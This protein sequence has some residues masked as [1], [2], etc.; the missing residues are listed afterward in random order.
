MNPPDDPLAYADAVFLPPHK[1]IGGPGTPGI[2]ALRRE[3]CRNRVPTVPGGGTV[4]YVNAREH[5]Y[6]DDPEQREEGGTPAIIESI[7]AG[8]VFQLKE[9][10]QA[11]GGASCAGPYGHR[12]L[13]I[14]LERSHQFAREISR[15]CEGIKPAWVR[16]SFNYFID[17]RVFEYVVEAVKLVAEH[18]WK[19]LPDYRFDPV[20]GLW[21]HR[22]GPLDPPL[23]LGAVRY[24]DG[25]MVVPRLDAR[26]PIEDLARYLEEARALMTSRP[27]EPDGR[28]GAFR[29]ISTEFEELRWLWL[30][31]SCVDLAR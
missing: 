21:H 18:G 2:L 22:A 14:E 24:V 29:S 19:L 30:P 12:L 9:G 28:P 6:I 17:E 23:S 13:G 16:V 26:A 15:G 11:R 3:L 4:T 20:A 27:G 1:F 8:L 5:R 25:H 7:R 31:E 10:I